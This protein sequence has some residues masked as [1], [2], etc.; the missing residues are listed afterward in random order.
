MLDFSFKDLGKTK[1]VYLPYANECNLILGLSNT[2]KTFLFDLLYEQSSSIEQLKEFNDDSSEIDDLDGLVYI[3]FNSRKRLK[4]VL[5][6][7]KLGISSLMV[8]DD[9]DDFADMMVKS[10]N[11]DDLKLFR[12]VCECLSEIKS[13]VLV[14]SK[15][16]IKGLHVKDRNIFEFDYSA[17]EFRL[18]PI[19]EDGI[20]GLKKNNYKL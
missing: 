10:R 2:G 15:E 12:E 1:K 6:Y 11:P 17:N 14:V 9:I 19:L 8:I 18:V 4:E 13:P 5:N 3:S 16:P 20:Y 7:A